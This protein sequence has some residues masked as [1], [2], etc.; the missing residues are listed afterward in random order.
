M[1]DIDDLSREELRELLKV[2]ALNWLAHDG[3]WFLAAEGERDWAAANSLNV[4]AWRNFTRIEAK[5]IL[6]FLGRAPG[7]GT[8]ALAEALGFRLYA[9]VNEQEIVHL[10]ERRLVFRMKDCRV[11]AARHRKGLPLHRCKAAGLVEYAGFAET[12]DPRL[13]TRCV[14]CPP[15]PVPEGSY[16]EWE[17]TL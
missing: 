16:C 9:N 2:Y 5:R 6:K 10:D 11:Q 12:I 3:C 14:H 7:G 17:F 1:R 4:E 15:D 13:R 8:K